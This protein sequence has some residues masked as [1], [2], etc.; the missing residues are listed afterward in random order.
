MA[1]PTPRP[2]S[3]CRSV[4]RSRRFGSTAGPA[5]R[6]APPHHL[7]AH[8]AR[9]RGGAIWGPSRSRGPPRGS[10]SPSPRP[11]PA[12]RGSW[13]AAP[14]PR[15]FVAPVYLAVNEKRRPSR[16]RC[17]WRRGSPGGISLPAPACASPTPSC[18]WVTPAERPLHPPQSDCQGPWAQARVGGEGATALRPASLTDPASTICQLCVFQPVGAPL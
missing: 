4:R 9:G 1:S 12:L 3:Q 7:T 14:P 17:P 6:S 18:R 13:A 11:A 10:G 15:P 5:Q 8:C 2:H 16:R